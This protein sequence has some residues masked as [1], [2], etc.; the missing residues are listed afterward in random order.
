MPKGDRNAALN[1]LRAAEKRAAQERNYTIDEATGCWIWGGA[2]AGDGYGKLKRQG[3]TLRAHRFF[4]SKLVGPIPAGLVVCHRCDTPLCVN[5]AHLFIGTHLD[6]E[7]DKDRKGRR[8]QS[9]SISH[10]QCLP[11]G[12]RHHKAKLT[13]VAVAEI[14]GSTTATR[15]LAERYGVSMSAIQRVRKGTTWGHI[16]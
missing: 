15:L 3:K 16:T 8:S 7:R 10:P 4:Y 11:R 5:P 13:D 14:R 1:R 9:P 12:S 2:I 6:N